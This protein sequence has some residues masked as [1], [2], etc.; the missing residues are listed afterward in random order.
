MVVGL[1]HGRTSLRAQPISGEPVPTQDASTATEADEPWNQGVSI[2]DREAAEELF[3][4]A[5]RLF[6][7][8][9][10]AKAAEQYAAALA[11]WKHP[12]FYY[13]LALAQLNQGKDVE[14]R[15]NLELALR[16]GEEPLGA[17]QFQEAQNKLRELERQLGQIRVTCQT[18][19]AEITLDG[20]RLF[21]GPG[22][23]QRW[24]SAKDYELTAKKAGYLSE[25]RRVTV[26]SGGL[27]DID[28]RLVTLSE[29]TDASRRWATWKPWMVVA[30]GGLIVTAGG[31]IHALAS[32]NFKIYDSEFE[33]LSCAQ[34]F[35]T[36]GCSQDT[37]GP[38]L[39]NRLSRA[40]L[41][42]TIAVGGYI[43]GGALI[44]AGAILLYLNRPR[45]EEQGSSVPS[46]KSVAVVPAVPGVTG[47]MF[48]LQVSVSH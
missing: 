35:P 18:K 8:P 48:G 24:V 12:A 27:Q 5:N 4:D 3:T 21:T 33:K 34:G 6:T 26:A 28:L 37:I 31:G 39:N 46:V 19:G 2:E 13:N 36:P 7:I 15:E 9:L 40:K 43:A 16:Y 23:H 45:L 42:Q 17:E 30:A 29:V 41:Q 38:D 1:L 22:R 10:F 32:K 25:S 47:G 11:K 20:V 14:A 44:T